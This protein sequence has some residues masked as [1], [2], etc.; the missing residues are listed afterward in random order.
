[1]VLA[2]SFQLYDHNHDG[3][4]TK[5]EVSVVVDAMH[6]M[7]GGLVEPEEQQHDTPQERVKRIFETINTVRLSL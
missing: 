2:G 7:V 6:R 5:E 4:I 3:Y 1:M